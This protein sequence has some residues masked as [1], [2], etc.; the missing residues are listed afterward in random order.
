MA[1]LMQGPQVESKPGES[2]IGSKPQAGPRAAWP[3]VVLAAR[4]SR[5]CKIPSCMWPC[6]ALA[7][8]RSKVAN[9]EYIGNLCSEPASLPTA[10]ARFCVADASPRN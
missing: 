3:M 4:P 8:P 7:Q 6:A 1:T 5:I 9:A 10:S 2:M